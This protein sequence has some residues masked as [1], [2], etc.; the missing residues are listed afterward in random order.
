[1]SSALSKASA[2]RDAAD[3]IRFE[4]ATRRLAM[5]VFNFRTVPKLNIRLI[6]RI[7]SAAARGGIRYDRVCSDSAACRNG[8]TGSI[9]E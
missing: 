3:T 7:E 6:A 2:A 9:A 8:T 4:G 1:M 5:G